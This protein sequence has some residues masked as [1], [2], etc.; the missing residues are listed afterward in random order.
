MTVPAGTAFG[1]DIGGTKVLGVALGADDVVRAETRMA[2]PHEASG[3]DQPPGPGELVAAA[4]ARV[5]LDLRRTHGDGPVGVGVPGML[6]RGGTLVF[7][8]NLH[9][10]EDAHLASMVG[11]R[12]GDTT[13]V[14]ENDANCAALAEHALGA[15]RGV[16]HALV[17]TLG[18]GIGGGLVVDGRVLT[19]GAGFAGEIGHMMVDRAGPPC[20]CG[21]RGCWER[22]AS[23]DGLG[24]LAREAAAGRRLD[25]VVQLA[26]G[27][28]EEVRGEH[29]TQAAQAGDPEALAVVDE[30]GWW[31]AMGLVNLTAAVDPERIV[32]GGGLLAL[33]ELLL[34]P[35]RRS[36]AAL[37][38]GGRRR[39]AIPI[40]G[41]A[42][43]ERAGAVGAALAARAGGFGR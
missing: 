13:V 33:G 41:A 29:V 42:M 43:G 18:T 17:V 8:P 12:L 7:S 26:G 6:D 31:V 32:L 27:D 30:L 22:F 1:V 15:A 5:V 38:E 23:G 28:P 11:E 39:R 20:P 3:R 10:A 24:R 2:T 9:G 16:D 21:S 40:V 36:F 25:A 34:E 14:V 19:G 35:T 4:V 37:V